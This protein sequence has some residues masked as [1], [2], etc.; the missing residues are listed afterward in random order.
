MTNFNFL[1]NLAK[2]NEVNRALAAKTL[3]NAGGGT[4]RHIALIIAKQFSQ[5]CVSRSEGAHTSEQ[6]PRYCVSRSEGTQVTS[7]R[8]AVD[9][10]VSSYGAPDEHPMSIRSAS[11][12]ERWQNR[13][14]KHVAM[15]FAVLVMSVGQMWG[16]NLHVE[17]CKW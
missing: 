6:F 12:G 9:V 16:E 4:S 1:S 14:W 3:Q 15:I 10:T 8:S 17:F 2:K 11:D 7:A 13:G 5:Y